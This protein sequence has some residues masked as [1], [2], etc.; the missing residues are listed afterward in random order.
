MKIAAV[1]PFS[2]HLGWR[3]NWIFVKVETDRR[4]GPAP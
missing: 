4:P 3:K 1:T 2:V